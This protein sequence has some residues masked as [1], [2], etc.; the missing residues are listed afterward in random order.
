MTRRI[1]S[2]FLCIVSLFA[3]CA[4]S[5]AEPAADEFLSEI[6]GSY[7]ELFPEMAKEEYHDDWLSAVAP[8]VGDENAEATIE[9]LLSM[10]MAEPYGE[11]AIALYA[12]D[13]AS[14][15]FNCYFIGGVDLF[16]ID[17]NTITGT[18]SEGNEVFSHSYT[19]IDVENENDFI[20][21]QSD[22]PDAGQFTY[23][24]FAPDT[25]ETTY[26]LEFRYSENIDDLQ[27]WFEGAYAYWNVGAF[28]ADYTDEVMYDVINLFATENLA[29]EE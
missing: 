17:G 6:T 27:S 26:H 9:L 10:C 1:L 2:F 3:L 13:P 11:E 7:V 24:A 23:F 25:M 8:L 12:E 29:G 16:T 22:D 5:Q 15:R 14:M 20:F 18:D 4:V 21:Y 19:R 28:A